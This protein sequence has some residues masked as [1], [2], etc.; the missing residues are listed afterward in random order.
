MSARDKD[1]LSEIELELSEFMIKYTDNET[2]ALHAASVLQKLAMLLYTRLLGP[3]DTRE[4]LETVA[5]SVDYVHEQVS[6]MEEGWSDDDD[7]YAG[8]DLTLKH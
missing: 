5:E 7:P 4:L 2:D 1:K 3:E 8:I 6:E